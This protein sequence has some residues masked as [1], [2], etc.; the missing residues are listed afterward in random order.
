M[1]IFTTGRSSENGRTHIGKGTV[2]E[3]MISSRDTIT[4]AGKVAGKVATEGMVVVEQDGTVDADI[5]ALEAFINGRV[6]GNI[7]ARKRVEITPT[8]RVQGDIE[9]AS[10]SIAEGVL[11]DGTCHMTGEKDR[12]KSD[13]FD[14]D[15]HPKGTV[16]AKD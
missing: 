4:I 7:T 13:P 5:T 15:T 14:P 6:D 10:L 11:F 9:S 3:G 16:Q 12:A 2:C 8:G 1:G